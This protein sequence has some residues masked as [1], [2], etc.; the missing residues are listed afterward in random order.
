MTF[1]ESWHAI[2]AEERSIIYA[3]FS[4]FIGPLD[5]MFK[6]AMEAGA[7]RTDMDRQLLRHLVFAPIL[8]LARMRMPY[9]DYTPKKISHAVWRMLETGIVRRPPA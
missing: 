6:E 2:E 4:G 7:V 3:F 9:A 5:E 1:F 8:G